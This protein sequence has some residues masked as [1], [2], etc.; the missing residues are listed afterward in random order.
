MG[1][2]RMVDLLDGRYRL[3]SELGR[4]GMA[5]VWRADDERL[6]RPVAVKL[7]DKAGLTDATMLARFDRE[8]RTAAAVAHPNVVSVHD[9]GVDDGVPYLVMELVE[10]HSLADE[11]NNGPLETE[12]AVRITDQVCAALEVAH[13]AGVI[14]RD[15]KPANILISDADAV[16]VCDFGIARATR[17]AYVN[18]TG[19]AAVVGTSSYMAPEQ[20]EGGHIDERT[21]L[22][23]LGCVLYAMLTGRPPFVGDSPMQ[24][25]WQ[26]LN[27][28]PAP[29]A[30]VR[31]GVPAGLDALVH[32]LLAKN[33][34]DRPAS[35]AAVR[36]RLRAVDGQTT[37]VLAA[38]PAAAA[39]N[40]TTRKI[41][42]PPVRGTAVVAPPMPERYVAEGVPVII[43]RRRVHPAWLA[44]AIAA[45]I[46]LAIIAALLLTRRD[47]NGRNGGPGTATT[48]ATP[49]ATA[50]TQPS[51]APPGSSAPSGS[52]PSGSTPSGSA[53]ASSQ[54]SH[55]NGAATKA[56]STLRSVISS[57][58]QSGQLDSAV[59]GD[60]N[61]QLDDV[62]QAI[63]DGNNE[64]ASG[65]IDD[66]RKTLSQAQK[67][68]NV[69]PV[70]Y[71]AISTAIDALAATLG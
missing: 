3:R 43:P 35:A 61:G 70:A 22:Y 50:S 63:A 62:S 51:T 49:P 4:G 13:A 34:A 11:L 38:T 57:Q 2:D 24:I 32:D 23:G 55:A 44:L 1:T 18:L 19:P 29:A 9:V 42:K 33:P 41:D 48:P 21:D 10:G 36:T 53:P 12:R 7:L 60:L 5:A 46:A 40:A 30:D 47:P 66:M 45:L 25:A 31:P 52:T 64:K 69:S 68:G 16:K 27:A 26:Q 59:A 71:A 17:E 65:K 37:A 28:T 67:D 15:V 39:A 54:P 8:A 20:V 14:H 56:V 6:A 58:S